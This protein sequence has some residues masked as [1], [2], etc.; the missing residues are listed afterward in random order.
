MPACAC[1]HVPT[2]RW[3]REP[4]VWARRGMRRTGWMHAHMRARTHTHACMYT[5]T[6]T[7]VNARMHA[8]THVR[9]HAPRF[10]FDHCLN[11]MDTADVAF[12]SQATTMHFTAPHRTALH[13]RTHAHAC[14]MHTR[15]QE[16]VFQTVGVPVA[17]NAWTGFNSTIFAY[18]STA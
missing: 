11:S 18:A 17:Q 8:L 4:C 1:A 15:M 9:L 12:A 13:R 7:C 3:L 10:D 16:T 5:D 2:H 14:A 6:C